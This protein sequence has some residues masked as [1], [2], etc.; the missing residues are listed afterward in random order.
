MQKEKIAIYDNEKELK[1][2]KLTLSD[3]RNVQVCLEEIEK[4]GDVGSTTISQ[5]VAN[6]FKKQ[7]FNVQQEDIGW[8]I[9]KRR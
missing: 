3:Y 7:G 6:W 9:K 4:N 1:R 8:R 2:A 5:S